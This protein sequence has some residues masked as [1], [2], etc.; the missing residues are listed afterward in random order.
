MIEFPQH[1]R[2]W[3]NVLMKHKTMPEL[4]AVLFLRD[5]EAPRDVIHKLKSQFPSLDT[6]TIATEVCFLHCTYP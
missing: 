3:L 2:P 5:V 6:D 1:K 4:E